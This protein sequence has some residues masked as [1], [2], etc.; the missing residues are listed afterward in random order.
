MNKELD[1][2]ILD[3]L[4]S[5]QSDIIISTLDYLS[6]KGSCEYIP[7]LADLLHSTKEADEDIRTKI[8]TI[9]SNIKQKNAAEKLVLLLQ[10]EQYREEWKTLALCCWSNGL[11]YTPYLSVF[12][13]LIINEPFETALEAFTVIENMDG[14]LPFAEKAECLNKIQNAI[15]KGKSPE[16][17]SYFLKEMIPIIEKI[18]ERE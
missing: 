7:Y 1:K 16:Q 4:S 6:E 13:D 15:D 3:N 12:I 14:F 5:K 8:I 11:D 9:L 18:N 2:K 10:N 17:Q